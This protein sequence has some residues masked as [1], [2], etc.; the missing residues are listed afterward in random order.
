MIEDVQALSAE[1]QALQDS[2]ERWAQQVIDAELDRPASE[3]RLARLML[4]AAILLNAIANVSRMDER[5]VQQLV[6][7]YRTRVQV[8]CRSGVARV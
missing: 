2:A 3:P 6:T 7:R 5:T 8:K 1:A 4:G